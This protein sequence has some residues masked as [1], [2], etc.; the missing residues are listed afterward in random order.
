MQ[1]LPQDWSPAP[2]PVLG[3]MEG[4]LRGQQKPKCFRALSSRPDRYYSAP[5]ESL[6]PALFR[7]VSAGPGEAAR[8]SAELQW[9]L[10]ILFD[11]APARKENRQLF[12]WH[13]QMTELGGARQREPQL[14]AEFILGW[15]KSPCHLLNS[16]QV[17]HTHPSS[18]AL[19]LSEPS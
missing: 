8:C 17:H 11:I 7:Q 9:E 1:Y 3:S 13:H 15:Q 6:S 10:A 12:P 19:N 4:N 5:A 2:A 16:T 14:T 18:W